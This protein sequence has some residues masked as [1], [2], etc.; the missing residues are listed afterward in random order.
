ME[1]QTFREIM[2]G[3]GIDN[4]SNFGRH[5]F[6]LD[7][8]AIVYSR[9]RDSSCL[10][11]SNF[12]AAL[13][14]LGGESDTV[15]IHSFNHWAVGWIEHI[16]VDPASKEK[17]EIAESIQSQLSDYPVLNEEDWCEREF[18]LA[19]EYWE[20]CSIA[21]RID[22]IQRYGMGASI[23]AARRPELPQDLDY[24]SFAV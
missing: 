8:W 19:S 13:T 12:D 24:S 18:N 14:A 7:D 16:F 10:D 22:A 4:Y 15:Q 20:Q 2:T 23:F 11:N 1:L 21:D 5:G 17:M 6:E 9:T 3:G